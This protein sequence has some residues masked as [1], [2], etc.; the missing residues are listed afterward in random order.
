M[1]KDWDE[2]ADYIDEDQSDIWHALQEAESG[3]DNIASLDAVYVDGYLE[4][5]VEEEEERQRKNAERFADYANETE[6]L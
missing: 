4:R 2:Y 5:L 3:A 1:T 6:G